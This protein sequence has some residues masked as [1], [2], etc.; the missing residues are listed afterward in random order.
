MEDRFAQTN[1]GRIHWL[2]AGSGDALILLHSNGCSAH[3]FQ[4]VFEPL[5]KQFRVIA[6][7]MP[8]HGDSDPITRHY[9]IA[10]YADAV[11]GL[12]DALG[13]GQAWVAGA[14]IGGLICVELG[15]VHPTRLKGVVIVEAMSKPEAEWKAQWPRIEA[16]FGA[17]VQSFDEV[18]PR[19]RDLTPQT[20]ARWNI[21]RAKAGVWT[22]MDVMWAIREYDVTQRSR[23][24]RSPSA[25]IWGEVGPV[26]DTIERWRAALPDSP[27]VMLP[28][29][30]HFP[31]IDDP[32]GFQQALLD[33]LRTMV[34]G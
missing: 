3:E 29:C 22:M 23:A 34:S 9:R 7:D 1:Q 33:C 15:A 19:F 18:R 25:V 28:G 5:A 26:K 11:V 20:H 6:W 14:S 27:C 10:D 31:M 13:I 21:D 30:G 17:D 12:M 24:I 16:T 8:G 32:E 4:Q 2:E